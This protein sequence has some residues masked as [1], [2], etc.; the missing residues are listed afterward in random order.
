MNDEELIKITES[1]EKKL[2]KEN[3]AVIS[4]DIGTLITGNSKNLE[5]IKTRD[6]TIEDLKS[7]NE[8]LINANGALLQKIPMGRS[9]EKPSSEEPV[10]KHLSFKDAFDENGNFKK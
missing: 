4:D 5:E 9:T 7:K 6:E 10:K 2:G 3:F 8:K 1:M